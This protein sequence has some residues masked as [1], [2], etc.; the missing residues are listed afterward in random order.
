MIGDQCAKI[1]RRGSTWIL[2]SELCVDVGAHLIALATNRRSAM[3]P[4]FSGR[5][6]V[7]TKPRERLLGNACGRTAPSG[8]KCRHSARR[9]RE[10]NGNAIG[11]R[12]CQRRS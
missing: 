6:P 9:M 4:K 1:D 12:D 5:E 10:K 11:D 3:Q 2:A 7:C 8:V